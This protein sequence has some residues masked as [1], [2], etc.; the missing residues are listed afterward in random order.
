MRTALHC[1]VGQ[2]LLKWGLIASI[3]LGIAG[4]HSTPAERRGANLWI[5]DIGI[6]TAPLPAPPTRPAG[7]TEGFFR[8]PADVALWIHPN[9]LSK[10]L[11]V[12]IDETYDG[13]G[14][15]VFGLDGKERQRLSTIVYPMDVELE[16]GV[17]LNGVRQDLIAILDRATK[18]ILF[19]SID[20]DSGT[21]KEVTGRTRVLD[22]L[23]GDAGAPT[24]LSMYRRQDGRTFALV[25]RKVDDGG[26]IIWQYELREQN[27]RINLSYVRDF[28]TFSGRGMLSQMLVDDYNGC[29][30]FYDRGQGIRKFHADPDV[31]N[32]DRELATFAFDGWEGPMTG[33]A[34][35]PGKKP[36]TG[37]LMALDTR[38]SMSRVRLF[39]REGRRGNP[40]EHEGDLGTYALRT[41]SAS[42]LDVN[43]QAL[44]DRFP[45]GLFVTGNT[46]TG[47]FDIFSWRRLQLVRRDWE[48]KLRRDK[49]RDMSRY[50]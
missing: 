46:G 44:D 3:A 37:F 35:W 47:R 22:D 45:E 27:G 42:G 48:A 28:G 8:N 1:T 5:P 41:E 13:D 32:P 18:R 9:D 7:S 34:L 38:G 26:G 33:L 14:A 36:G 2:R 24:A 16:Y 12:G 10:S 17:T 20:P 19:F 15:T 6:T 30:F 31:E 49:V 40:D 21:L 50:D 29:V 11:I 25:A 43:P 4:C 23:K 39:P